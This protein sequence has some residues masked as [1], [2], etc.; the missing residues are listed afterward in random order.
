M[1][2]GVIP[3][4]GGSKGVPRKN[5]RLLAGKPLLAWS[6]EAAQASKLLDRTV[7]STEDPEIAEAARRY[8]AEVLARPAALASDE[9]ITL[10]VLQHALEQIPAE[11]VVLLQPTSPVREA[12]LVD[13]CIERFRKSG[14]DS[15]ATGYWCKAQE[16]GTT[17]T[18]RQDFPGFFVDDG[19][20]YVIKAE[21]LRRGDRYGKKIE[22]MVLDRKQNLDLDDEFDFRMAEQILR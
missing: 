1:I 15:L 22:R 14:A 11:T 9:T 2:L 5:I 6:I 13:R 21:L 16:Y 8:G 10:P 7:V 3:A 20:I 17:Q 4:R 12:G 18:R 19:N